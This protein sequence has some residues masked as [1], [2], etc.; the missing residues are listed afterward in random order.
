M[1]FSRAMALRPKNMA[2]TTT[3]ESMLKAKS[4]SFCA[5]NR[6]QKTRRARSKP[7]PAIQI[8]PRYGL[9]QTMPAT[10]ARLG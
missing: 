7:L 10:M 2:T 5:T 3:R 6:R 8:M 4:C 9:K 1:L